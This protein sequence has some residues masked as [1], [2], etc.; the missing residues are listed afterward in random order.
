MNYT[1]VHA[2]IHT[3]DLDEHLERIARAAHDRMKY[4]R[5]KATKRNINT[6]SPGDIVEI[7]GLRPK[8]ING[9]H[10]EVVEI[11][12]TKVSIRI[13]EAHRGRAKR[14]GFGIVKA[15]AANLTPVG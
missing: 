6:L 3:G 1:D 4:L 11:H 8:Y 15:P 7:D 12:R 9:L 14:F 2:A 5:E 10:A 13:I